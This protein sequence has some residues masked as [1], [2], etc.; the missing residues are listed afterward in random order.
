MYRNR[1]DASIAVISPDVAKEIVVMDE[2]MRKMLERRT[3][4]LS[5]SD[6]GLKDIGKKVKAVSNEIAIIDDEI[7]KMTNR[8]E[9]SIEKLEAMRKRPYCYAT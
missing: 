4:Q 6:S 9:K 7:V 8:V 5:A 2:E 3:T 1:I